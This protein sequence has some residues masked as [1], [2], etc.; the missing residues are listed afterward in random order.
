MPDGTVVLAMVAPGAKL[1]EEDKRVLAEY[2]QFCRDRKAKQQR[3][4]ERKGAR[5]QR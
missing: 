5:S 1:T 3:E 2:A 4:K